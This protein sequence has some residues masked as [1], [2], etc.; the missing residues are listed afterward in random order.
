MCRLNL[1]KAIYLQNLLSRKIIREDRFDASIKTVAGVDVAYLGGYG[2]GSVV[3]IDYNTLK[4]IERKYSLVKVDI[5]YIPTFLAFREVPPILKAI[6]ELDNA[7]DIIL[8][9]AHGVMHPR[10]LGAASHIGV[11][12]NIPTIGVAKSR[13]VG[14]VKSN[15]YIYYRGEI[16]GYRLDKK[17]YI[18]TGHMVSLESAISIVSHLT[19]H[20][21]PEPTRL[22]HNYA[23]EIKRDIKRDP[24]KY[25]LKNDLLR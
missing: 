11:V 10:K 23:N 2:I 7:P 16:V 22:A 15:G 13:L 18:S 14:E 19:I 20:S 24:D 9:D 6:K 25:M 5:P 21:V 3:L 4:L 8:V 17:I 1:K 12:L